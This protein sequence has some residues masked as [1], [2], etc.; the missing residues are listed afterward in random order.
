MKGILQ[1]LI[2]LQSIE[3]SKIENENDNITM[4]ELRNR[5]PPQILAH[6][7]R[8]VARGKKGIAAVHHQIC[9]GCHMSVPIGVILTLRHGDDI[10]LCENCGRYLYLDGPAETVEPVK[11]NRSRRKAAQLASA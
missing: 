3:F 4:F 7:D 8:L 6:Y 9:S 2:R 10:Q 1:N 11:K 5:I